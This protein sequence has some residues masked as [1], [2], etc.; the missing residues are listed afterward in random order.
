MILFLQIISGCLLLQYLFALWNIAQLPKLGI[1]KSIHT[2]KVSGSSSTEECNRRMS[3]LIPARDEAD[4]IGDCL[5]SVLA[6]TSTGWDLEVIVLDDRSS[7]ETGRIARA[8]GDE[9]VKVVDGRE[10]PDGWLGKSYAC[11]QL[12]EASS[13]EW[14]L[15]LDAD[16]RLKPE[17][18]ENA[19]AMAEAQEEGLITGF[20]YQHT[21]TWLEK[22]VVPL[23]TFTIIC[24]LPIPLVRASRDP[25]FVAAHGGFMLVHRNSYM[26]CGG[27]AAIRTDLVDDMALA[28]GIKKAGDQVT[29]AD[30]TEYAEM[31]MYHNASEVWSGYRKNIYAGLGRRPVILLGMLSLYTLLYVFPLAAFFFFCATGQATEAAWAL[32][33]SLLGI[34]IK[35]ISDASARQSVWLCLLISGSIV[36]LLAIAISSWWGSRPGQG[37]EWKGRRYL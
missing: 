30:I 5:A 24:H 9:R 20:A 33:S 26:R 1:S 21:G 10:L 23:M 3:V 19:L 17:A 31:R 15:F 37:Y 14:L 29:L 2:T 16:I 36:C 27:H 22:L 8:T 25:R 34:A 18:L 4:N 11:N 28:R 13:G 6:C 32:S 7:D 12:V 35:R